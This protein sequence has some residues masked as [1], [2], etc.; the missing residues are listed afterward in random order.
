MGII[1]ISKDV[2]RAGDK[3]KRQRKLDYILDLPC[4][5]ENVRRAVTSP[6]G[7]E[8]FI[9]VV[10]HYYYVYINVYTYTQNEFM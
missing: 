1:K 7:A 6:D 5:L 10:S 8:D 2:L 4:I 3:S 9:I